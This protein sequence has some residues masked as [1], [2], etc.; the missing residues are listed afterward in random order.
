MRERESRTVLSWRGR[1]VHP[2]LTRAARLLC[3]CF[4]DAAV[5][6]TW[7]H[8]QGAT[9]A[10]CVEPMRLSWQ[11]AS[12][13]RHRLAGRAERERVGRKGE[14]EREG[15][16]AMHGADARQ[17]SGLV[18]SRRIARQRLAIRDS[19]K[20]SAS[21]ASAIRRYGD[22][23]I[24]RIRGCQPDRAGHNAGATQHKRHRLHIFIIPSKH[25]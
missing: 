20:M 8:S 1:P 6:L 18:E 3:L 19:V 25:R 5:L 16:Q 10:P 23:V 22:S 15:R 9:Q 4:C 14:G 21:A 2:F 24:P 7:M 11:A 13:G 17:G 12:P